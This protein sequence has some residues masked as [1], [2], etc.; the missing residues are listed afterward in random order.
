MLFEDVKRAYNDKTVVGD[1]LP[2]L[3]SFSLLFAKRRF[4]KRAFER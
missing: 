2:K 3:I 1:Q 4:Q